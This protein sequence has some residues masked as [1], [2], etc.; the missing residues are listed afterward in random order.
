MGLLSWGGGGGFGRGG[1][2]GC[3][4]FPPD[5]AV[6]DAV[7][8]RHV[9]LDVVG[10]GAGQTGL[11]RGGRPDGA[12]PRLHLN[13]GEVDDADPRQRVRQAV[14]EAPGIDAD[15]EGAPGP[16]QRGHGPVRDGACGSGKGVSVPRD[17]LGVGGGVGMTCSAQ[18]PAGG[19]PDGH[20]GPPSQGCIAPLP[21]QPLSP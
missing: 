12:D 1:D 14:H 13:V 10:R 7:L 8:L 2:G 6:S 20:A 15:P 11:R 17:G 3:P 4:C 18:A 9:R 16:C 19:L 5:L 21:A